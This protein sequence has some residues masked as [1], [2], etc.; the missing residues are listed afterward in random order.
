M[1]AL[2]MRRGNSLIDYDY[3]RVSLAFWK[4]IR[5]LEPFDRAR[6][7]AGRPHVLRRLRG[8]G[9]PVA[10]LPA[11]VALRRGR[12]LHQTLDVVVD[13]YIQ[14]RFD[15]NFLLFQKLNR[16]TMSI[17]DLDLGMAIY[18]NVLFIFCFVVYCRSTSQSIHSS[19]FARAF[20]FS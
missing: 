16:D 13:K 3:Q 14:Q 20:V 1:K 17:S 10:P 2:K 12:Q 8:D 7:E 6:E 9:A 4:Y 11:L 18:H 15:I 19:I 5:G